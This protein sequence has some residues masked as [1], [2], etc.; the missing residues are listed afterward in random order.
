MVSTPP[1][2]SCPR[3]LAA[4]AHTDPEL[5]AAVAEVDGSLIDELLSLPVAARV[6]WSVD[7]A[8]ALEELRRAAIRAD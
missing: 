6:A 2:T 5:A 4:L 1:N 8:S 3:L 7:A